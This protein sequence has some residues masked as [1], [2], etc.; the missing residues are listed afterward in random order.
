MLV[1]IG[2]IQL[3]IHLG[4]IN[5][6]VTYALSNIQNMVEKGVR[7]IV[8]PELWTSGFDY[9]H[10]EKIAE[11]T[12]KILQEVQ[13]IIT[14]NT[15]VIGTLP[16]IKKGKLYNTA[17]LIDKTGLLDFYQKSHLFTPSGEDKHFTPGKKL[18]VTPS[19]LGKIGVLICYDLRFPELAR[20]FNIKRCGNIGHKCS[21]G[22]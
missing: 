6:N 11:T 22:L 21:L 9:K 18:V 1:K 20:L 13:Q 14:A 3:D 7:L 17:F 15:L 4:E 2:I 10:L 16:E 8:L 19:Y 12:P 5:R